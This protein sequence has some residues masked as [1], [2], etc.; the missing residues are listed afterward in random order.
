M[1]TCNG[2]GVHA[3]SRKLADARAMAS[4]IAKEYDWGPVEIERVEHLDG[5]SVRYWMRQRK[6][7][8]LW[9]PR[10]DVEDRQP[11]WLWRYA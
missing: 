4:R 1:V 7:W 11:D 9:N 6:R 8:V 3:T 10:R 5:G 2:A